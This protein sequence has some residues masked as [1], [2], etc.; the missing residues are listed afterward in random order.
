ML[1]V[2]F[3]LPAQAQQYIPSTIDSV[4]SP[5]RVATQPSDAYIGLSLLESGEVRHYNYGEQAEP[6]TFYLSS[7]DKGL[8][9][10][11]L[12]Y[13]KDMVFADRQSPVS[14]EYVSSG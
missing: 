11:K 2:W 10:K 7:M 1:V 13:A 6:G 3:F 12:P 5:V 14:K 4:F 8:T 9:W